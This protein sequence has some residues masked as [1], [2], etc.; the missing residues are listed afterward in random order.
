M[1]MKAEDWK[2]LSVFMFISVKSHL[3]VFCLESLVLFK[4]MME[5]P[6]KIF[7]ILHYWQ[8]NKILVI[9]EKSLAVTENPNKAREEST[10]CQF[11]FAN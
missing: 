3:R 9:L 2:I 6:N 8:S 10:I 5:K 7:V 1:K 11:L 4:Q